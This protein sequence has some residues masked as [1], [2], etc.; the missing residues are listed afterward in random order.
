MG[1]GRS[2]TPP[3]SVLGSSLASW[4]TAALAKRGSSCMLRRLTCNCS[5]SPRRREERT[6][7]WRRTSSLSSSAAAA[8]APLRES[9]RRGAPTLDKLPLLSDDWDETDE[10][11]ELDMLPLALPL[12]DIDW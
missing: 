5:T 2:T 7:E 8:A 1:G 3:L 6:D 9:R 10:R 11:D 4:L 12:D